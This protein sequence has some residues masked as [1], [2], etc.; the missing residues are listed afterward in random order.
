MKIG[1]RLYK[2]GDSMAIQTDCSNEQE[3]VEMF[4]ELLG[5]MVQEQRYEGDWEFQLS[6]WLPQFVDL[7][8]AYR[9]YKA[10]VE[11]QTMMTVGSRI[12]PDKPSHEISRQKTETDA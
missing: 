7:C 9:G 3:F 1:I 10:D 6:Y 8:C 2:S 11:K 4:T 5:G 12:V